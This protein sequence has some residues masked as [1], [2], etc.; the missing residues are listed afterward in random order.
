MSKD[1]EY[2]PPHN[3]M[4]ALAA[5]TIIIKESH[6]NLSRKLDLLIR[7]VLN[8]ATE[9]DHLNA[10]VAKI[11][12]DVDAAVAD[13]ADISAKLTAALAKGDPAEV[14]AAAEAAATSLDG[15][16]AKLEAVLPAPAAP[17]A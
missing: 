2:R 3:P 16:A 9:L 12:T 1:A 7:K 5:L 6:Y 13:I 15:V 14:L 17:A 11:S 8:M 4:E 10:A